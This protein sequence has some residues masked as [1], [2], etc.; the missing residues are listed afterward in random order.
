[1]EVGV[2]VGATVAV[3]SNSR[4][5]VRTDIDVGVNVG[6]SV[7]VGVRLATVMEGRLVNVPEGWR[8]FSGVWERLNAIAVNLASAV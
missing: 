8:V 5:G 3:L 1:M 6:C 4:E 7:C 2:K